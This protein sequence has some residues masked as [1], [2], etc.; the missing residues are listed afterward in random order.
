[1]TTKSGSDAPD[2]QT[3]KITTTTSGNQRRKIGSKAQRW[4]S[5]G[6]RPN[7][8]ANVNRYKPSGMSQNNGIAATSVVRCDVTL[9]SKLDGINASTIQRP[10]CAQLI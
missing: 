5:L 1:M 2:S 9:K 3:N 8:S 6:F 10:R 7:T 4:P